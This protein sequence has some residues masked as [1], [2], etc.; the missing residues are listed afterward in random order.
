MRGRD[1]LCWA[2]DCFVV[3]WISW[4]GATMIE[5][6]NICSFFFIFVKLYGIIDDRYSCCAKIYKYKKMMYKKV[7]YMILLALYCHIHKIIL[8]LTHIL[9]EYH[10]WLWLRLVKI[11]QNV[12]YRD[13][14]MCLWMC[15]W[16]RL[17]R[18]AWR[19]TLWVKVERGW[20]GIKINTGAI[21][22]E[23]S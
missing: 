3:V 8:L 15:L 4:L 6:I 20:H 18:Q 2:C 17:V 7:T 10:I 5:L 21:R 1:I 16:L 23:N 14:M 12:F 22:V 9:V 13:A 11:Y 19:C